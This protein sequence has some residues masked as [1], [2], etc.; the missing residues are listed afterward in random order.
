MNERKDW[1]FLQHLDPS[2]L[3]TNVKDLK[4]FVKDVVEEL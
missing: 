3:N 1:H 4:E 2:F